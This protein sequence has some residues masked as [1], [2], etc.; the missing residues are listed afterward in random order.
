MSRKIVTTSLTA[1]ALFSNLSAEPC[2][3]QEAPMLSPEQALTSVPANPQD[4]SAPAL[5]KRQL[6][7]DLTLIASAKS[8]REFRTGASGELYQALKNIVKE[9]K[10]QIPD[11]EW[12]QINGSPAGRVYATL[13][14]SRIENTTAA[15]AL[16]SLKRD[17]DTNVEV[18]AGGSKCHYTLTEIIID[19]SSKTPVIRLLP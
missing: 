2:R 12:I 9:G 10:S 19:Q 3:A 11:L 14:L 8:L 18:F 6:S 7:A 17:D 16:K 13:L 15:E 4:P 5:E 1:F